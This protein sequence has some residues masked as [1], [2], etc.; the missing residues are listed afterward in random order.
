MKLL[1]FILGMLF[2]QYGV[3]IL[4]ECLSLLLTAIEVIN[5][6]LNLIITEISVKLNNIS[7]S[8]NNTSGPI[9][10]SYVEDYEKE[11]ET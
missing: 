10:F 11:E 6:K 2:L 4:D 8:S 3:P 7:K 1:F 5:G 9:G